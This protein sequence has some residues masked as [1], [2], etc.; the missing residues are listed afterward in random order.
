V[1]FRRTVYR[2]ENLDQSA[3]LPPAAKV[4]AC[5]SLALWLGILTAGRWI[6]YFEPAAGN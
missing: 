2:N 4:A 3:T 5:L 6:A 1:V